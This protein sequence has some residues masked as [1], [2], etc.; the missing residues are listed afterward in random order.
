[1]ISTKIKSK[2]SLGI[3]N[4]GDHYIEEINFISENFKKFLPSTNIIVSNN[5]KEINDCEVKI[6]VGYTNYIRKSDLY[7]FKEDFNI[8]NKTTILGWLYIE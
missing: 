2:N 6:I 4:L 1:M 8:I 7:S 5:Y 3:I